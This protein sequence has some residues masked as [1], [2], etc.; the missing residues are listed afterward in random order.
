MR[1]CFGR[2]LVM[3]ILSLL[4]IVPVVAEGFF[5]DR[6]RGWFWYEEPPIAADD[7]KAP[8]AP[9]V[10]LMPSPTLVPPIAASAA[11]TAK[12]QLKQQGEALEAAMAQAILHPTP[13]NYRT[14]LEQSKQVQ[15]QSQQF[16][17]GLQQTTWLH[18]EYDYTLKSPNNAQAII[19]KNEQA[20][21]ADNA[22]I[23]KLANETGLLFFFRSD[24]PYCHRFAPILKKFSEYFGFTVIPISLDGPGLEEYPD[25]QSDLSLVQQFNISVV[26]AVG[27]LVPQT[28]GV[29]MVGYGFNDWRMLTKKVL[30]AGQQ[31]SRKYEVL[32]IKY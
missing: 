4:P 12:E 30:L 17:Q 23:A 14:Y 6:E 13:E 24:C 15:A 22:A 20:N 27:L 21:V 29:T 16:A 11:L 26:P 19:A 8:E 3:F 28:N 7:V 32:S 1:F 25:P 9:P 2:W 10:T 5:N 18:P 31:V